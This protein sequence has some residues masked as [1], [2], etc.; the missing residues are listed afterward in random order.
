MPFATVSVEVR[1]QRL[2]VLSR[3]RCEYLYGAILEGEVA[4]P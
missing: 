4:L 3:F 2:S 1:S